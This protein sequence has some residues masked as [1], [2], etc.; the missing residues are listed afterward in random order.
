M[1]LALQLSL[2]DSNDEFSLLCR[3]DTR[4][5]T[6]MDNYHRSLRVALD[7]LSKVTTLQ[8]QEIVI[9]REFLLNK[10]GATLP[11]L[12]PLPSLPKKRGKKAKIEEMHPNL[13]GIK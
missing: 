12:T 1:A 13:P 11:D 8:Q 5:E 3:E 6:K 2:L 10:C 4:L 7:H 9:L